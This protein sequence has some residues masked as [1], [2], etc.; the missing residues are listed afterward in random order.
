LAIPRSASLE[1]EIEEEEAFS[2]GIKGVLHTLLEHK[3]HRAGVVGAFVELANEW[4]DGEIKRRI[5]ERAFHGTLEKRRQLGIFLFRVVP[6][7]MLSSE[8]FLIANQIAGDLLG[9]KDPE[10]LRPKDRFFGT[11]GNIRE[12]VRK[13]D[14]PRNKRT[15]FLADP[16]FGNSVVVDLDWLIKDEILNTN[17]A[18]EALQAHIRRQRRKLGPEAVVRLHV[19]RMWDAGDTSK[20]KT[21]YKTK[22]TALIFVWVD[23]KL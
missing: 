12:D 8:V 19:V 7:S 20:S 16:K 21:K 23:L 3:E 13:Q 22:A 4:Q 14:E 6:Q 18:R 5:L 17:P 2:R 1:D 10:T 9:G 11:L 15:T